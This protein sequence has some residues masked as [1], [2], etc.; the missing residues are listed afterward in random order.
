MPAGHALEVIS[1]PIHLIALLDAVASSLFRRPES[2]SDKLV[3]NTLI[4]RATRPNGQRLLRI[5]GL[6]L[7]LL[8]FSL[9]LILIC[10]HRSPLYIA[11][12]L[13]RIVFG[14]FAMSHLYLLR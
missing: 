11:L 13:F 12:P 2:S 9:L 8:F 6:F 4:T 14:S 5:N 10:Q 1:N 7:S 3:G